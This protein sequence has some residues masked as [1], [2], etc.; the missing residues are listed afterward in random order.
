MY[1]YSGLFQL[2]TSSWD[3]RLKSM[4]VEAWKPHKCAA[5]FAESQSIY[6]GSWTL[7]TDEAEVQAKNYSSVQD[8][9]GVLPDQITMLGK[10]TNSFN[11]QI[12][13]DLA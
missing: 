8:M 13:N 4:Q 10:G 2:G 7:P 12:F 9:A 5:Q 11:F 1:F 3:M 6:T